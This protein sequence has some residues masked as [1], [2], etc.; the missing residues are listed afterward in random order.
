MQRQVRLNPDKIE[1]VSWECVHFTTDSASATL[2]HFAG[3]DSMLVCRF[4]ARSSS[5]LMEGIAKSLKFPSYFGHNWDALDE[6]LRDL[7]WLKFEALVLWVENAGDLWRN[8]TH[9]AGMLVGI[10]LSAAEEWSGEGKPFHL[11][12]H[13]GE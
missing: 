13:I 5:S 9:D 4:D 10:W 6:C 1:S 7:S 8:S 11:V 12:F 2:S 3:R